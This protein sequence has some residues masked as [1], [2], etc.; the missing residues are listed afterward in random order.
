MEQNDLL[1]LISGV[2]IGAGCTYLFA[3]RDGRRLRRRLHQR[4]ARL[5]ETSQ[6]W[7]ESGKQLVD[8]GV[9]L[10][11]DVGDFV[12]SKVHASNV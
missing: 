10:A 4:G 2:G 1:W 3:T 6:D 12:G 7:V 11:N 9:E 5:V 8:R